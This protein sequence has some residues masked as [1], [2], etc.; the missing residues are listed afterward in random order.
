MPSGARR[1]SWSTTEPDEAFEAMRAAYTEHEPRLDGDVSAFRFERASRSAAAFAVDRMTFSAGFSSGS[2]PATARVIVSQP[3][4]DSPLVITSD[5]RTTAGPVMLTPTW[6]RFATR[7]NDVDLRLTTI[8]AAQVAR[9]G[10]EISGL[11]PYEVA[12]AGIEPLTPALGRYW[13]GLTAHVHDTVLADDVDPPRLLLAEVRRQLATAA[14]VVFPNSTQRDGS[15]P[16]EHAEPASVRR[17]VEFIDAHAAQ[18]IDITRIAEA[19][20]VGV[21]GLQAAFRR[22]RGTS[23]TAYLRRVRLQGAHRDLVAADPTPG[24]TVA[25][26]AAQWG[27][28]HPGRFSVEYRAAFGHSPSEALRR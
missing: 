20:G 9:R 27:F 18:D 21:R 11:A 17:A 16:T 19:A 26:V 2:A 6:T 5:R 24:V 4:T 13:A 28:A 7:W 10:A 23:P 22:H 12:F 14:L 1:D 3:L 25:S 8:D 15:R